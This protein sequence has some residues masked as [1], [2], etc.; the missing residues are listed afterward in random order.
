MG[1]DLFILKSWDE[2]VL[3]FTNNLQIIRN[4]PTKKAV[5]DIRVSV[6]KIR[7]YL[8][9]RQEITGEKWN[10]QFAGTK[11]LF[12]TL[13]K[14]RD[15][16]MTLALLSKYHRKENTSLIHF[17]KFLQL[18]CRLAR[19]WSKR[20]TAE[21]KEEELQN[22][23]NSFYTSF[24]PVAN[25]ELINRIR[26]MAEKTLKKLSKLL[27]SFKKNV[28]EIRKLLKDL[29]YWLKACP[30]NPVENLIRLKVLENIL[31][32]LGKWQDYFIFLRKLKD[33]K[34]EFLVKGSE[35]FTMTTNCE[36]T[37]KT[38]QDELLSKIKT[39]ARFSFLK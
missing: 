31:R 23:T 12:Q 15:L 33:F 18:N 1:E 14:Q 30:E 17:K 27:G 13:G 35:E 36:E 16:E 25:E 20:A 8:R 4:R 9:L 24:S 26:E 37:M 34:K 6:K 10:E 29:Y 38:L 2:Q 7:A 22:L 21:Y 5:H 19:Q 28:H 32:N 39:T 11:I 3:V